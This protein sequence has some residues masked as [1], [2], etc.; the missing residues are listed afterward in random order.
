MTR[1][2]CVVVGTGPGNGSALARRFDAAGYRVACWSRS[3][4]TSQPLAD[5][6]QEGRFDAVDVSD[7][8]QVKRAMH[9][10]TEAWGPVHT[11]CYNAGSGVFGTVEEVDRAAL[12][13][14]WRINVLGLFEAVRTA[15][16]GM[17]Q[18]GGG[19]ILV[20]GATAS[21]RGG[22]RFAAFA[23]AKAAQRS[24]VQSMARHYWGQGVHVAL[25]I[26]DGIVDLPR[27]RKRMPDLPMGRMLQP[28][29]VAEAFYFLSQQHRSAWSF[30][31]D[32]RPHLETW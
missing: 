13:Q 22:A 5:S 16:P 31:V 20:T 19:N 14:A 6:L 1:P 2:T 3:A 12:E 10:L 27:T 17:V 30:E 15:A 26:V 8:D 24:L 7:P 9:D 28:D 32:V 25:V 18:A 21:L 23:Q 11:V 29:A 4:D